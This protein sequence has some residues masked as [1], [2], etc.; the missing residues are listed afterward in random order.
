MPI[1]LRVF[2]KNYINII[3]QHCPCRN[4]RIRQ[5]SEYSDFIVIAK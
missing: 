3:S 5:K 4:G 2:Q 1:T